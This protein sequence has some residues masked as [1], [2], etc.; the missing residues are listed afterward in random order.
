MLLKF[1]ETKFFPAWQST[2]IGKFDVLMYNFL[3]FYTYCNRFFNLV[4]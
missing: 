3:S 2:K 1:L 4:F